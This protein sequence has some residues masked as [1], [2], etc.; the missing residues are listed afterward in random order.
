VRK[1]VAALAILSVVFVIGCQDTKKVTEL[2]GQVDKLTQE[3]DQAKMDLAKKTAECDSLAK[4]IADM[5]AKTPAAKGTKGTT[6]APTPK[7][8]T[9]KPPK[10]GR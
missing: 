3:L 9:G 4:V 6:P 5:S 2:Q 7:A 8:P 1:L 10:V